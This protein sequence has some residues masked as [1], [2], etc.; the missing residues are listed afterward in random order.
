MVTEIALE[1]EDYQQSIKA[2]HRA[3]RCSCSMRNARSPCPQI[4]AGA[5]EAPLESG[6]GP[7][8]HF[9]VGSD[10]KALGPK[11]PHIP[12]AN[13]VTLLAEIIRVR[14]FGLGL[15]VLRL[16]TSKK[17]S[18]FT[19]LECFPFWN[20][21]KET[22]LRIVRGSFSCACIVLKQLLFAWGCDSGPARKS[23]RS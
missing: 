10:S 14:G 18:T 5:P 2:L 4:P 20:V 1:P 8:L 17:T 21:A 23:H 12:A 7:S 19:V 9:V 3:D 6:W 15:K 13:V 11:S 22:T 16:T